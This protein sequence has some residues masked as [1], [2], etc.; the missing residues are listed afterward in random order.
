MYNQDCHTLTL[1]CE[2][3][4]VSF[5]NTAP[6]NGVGHSRDRLL[7]H[8]AGTYEVSFEIC[9][10]PGLS[11]EITAEVTENCASLP[12][13]RQ[14]L[15][16]G[17]GRHTLMSHTALVS[18]EAG[19]EIGLRLCADERTRADLTYAHLLLKRIG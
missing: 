16:A 15:R 10:S 2:P 9:F 1:G 6:T 13:A 17:V 11:A 3:V 5:P 19:A 18:L 8:T 14:T 4:A 12:L 7:I